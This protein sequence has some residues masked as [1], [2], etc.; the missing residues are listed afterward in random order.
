MKRRILLFTLVICIHQLLSAQK[1]TI[2]VS[3]T[4][5]DSVTSE[6]VTHATVSIK[7]TPHKMYTDDRG[8]FSFN[9]EGNFPITIS[10]THTSFE[11]RDI[12]MEGY[13]SMTIQLKPSGQL[14]EVVI[15]A[16]DKRRTALM[17]A[18]VSVEYIGLRNIRNSPSPDYYNNFAGKKGVDITTSSLTFNTV[19]TRGFNGSGSS[20]V[21]Q[22][23]DGM[24]NQAPGLNFF[25]GNFVGLTEMDVESMELLPG[26]SSTMYGPG[27]M[28]G[29]IL[30]NSKSPFRYQ[31]LSIQVKQG[32]MHVDKS[33][34]DKV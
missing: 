22:L 29:T 9:V 31:G 19:S 3:G 15:T 25:V 30:I 6:P 16:V 7:G 34:R 20:R 32:I 8:Y 28:N 5:T 17:S 10:V 24:D 12:V 27:G 11:A 13:S 21:N 33:Q 1:Q 14:N 23:V 18:P 4:V 26:A 2:Q